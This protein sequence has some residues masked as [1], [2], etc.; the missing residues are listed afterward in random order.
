NFTREA[1]GVV[2]D[3][4]NRRMDSNHKSHTSILIP[5]G[6]GIG[7][8]RA[9]YELQHLIAHTDQLGLNI[10]VKSEDLSAF[11]TALQNSCYLYIN[12]KEE[13]SYTYAIDE[14]QPSDLRIGVRLAIAA[15]LGPKSLAMM[16]NYPLELYTVD[17]VLQEISKRRLSTS[18]R[19]IEA[20]IIHIDEYQEYITS[21]QSVGE[22]TYENAL[23]HFKEMLGS[24]GRLMVTSNSNQPYFI[25]PVCT[26]T[27]AIDEHFLHSDYGKKSIQ[28]RPLNYKA[29]V[30]M[31]RDKY[32][33]L[34]LSEVVENQP[35]FR[36][37]MND[38]GFVPTFIDNLLKPENLSDE[39]DWGN[40]LFLW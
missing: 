7:K 40:T 19:T 38:T 13:C 5:G 16:T 9:G 25:V 2:E 33:V 1:I 37:A 17:S 32:G 35:H 15:G 24:I 22:R 23:K 27:S 20:I 26:G 31:F 8:T 36:I 34:P 10:N 6:S 12:L 30:Q 11:R 4:Y 39:Y 3:N 29:A 18:K 28:L 21:A 14:N